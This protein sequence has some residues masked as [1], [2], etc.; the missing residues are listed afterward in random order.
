[1]NYLSVLR[2]AIRRLLRRPVL[3]IAAMVTLGLAIGA[4]TAVFSVVNGVLLKPLPYPQ[5]DDLVHLYRTQ[6]PV[7]GSPISRP[8][9][10]E[11]AGRTDL[12]VTVAGYTREGATL[13]GADKAERIYKA[14]TT[15][16]FFQVLGMQPAAG[17]WIGAADDAPNAQ[18]SA[19]LAYGLARQRFGSPA[20]ALGKSVRVDGVSYT[21][22]GVAPPGLDMPAGT[23]VWL[24]SRFWKSDS[25]WG[26]N[27]VM[28]IG[29]L[30]PGTTIDSASQRMNA[31]A[32][33]WAADRPENHRDLS[34]QVVSFRKSEVGDVQDT[35]WILMGAVLLVL[36]VACTNVAN[37]IIAR[38]LSRSRELATHAAIGASR[39]SL[40]GL[41][42]T[43]AVVLAA[44]GAVLGVLIASGS[45]RLLLSLAPQSLPRVSTVSIDGGVLAFTLLITLLAMLAAAIVPAWAAGNVAPA[46]ALNASGRQPGSAR[47]HWRSGLVCGEI[48]VSLVLLVGA[49]IL[50]GSL[51]RLSAVNPGFD[52]NNLLVAKVL[53]PAPAPEQSDDAAPYLGQARLNDEFLQ[54]VVSAATALPGVQRAAAVDAAPLT[55]SNWSGDVTIAGEDYAPGEEPTVDWRWATP[56]YFETAGIPLLKGRV[57]T[58]ADRA[59]TERVAVVSRSFAEKLLGD[60]D[61]LGR[62]FKTLGDLE[63]RIVGIVGDVRQN[64][65]FWK[66]GPT[67]YFRMGQAPAPSNSTLVLRTTVPPDSLARPL[68]DAV[69]GIDRDVPVYAVYS[70]RQIMLQSIARQRFA[71]LLMALFAAT[72]VAIAAVGLFGVMSYTVSLRT[73]D[74]GVRMAIGASRRRVLRAILGEGLRLAGLGSL[75]GNG[76]ALAASGL[77]ASLVFELSPREPWLYLLATGLLMA[78]AA[79]ASLIPAWR[80][81]RVNPV[82]ALRYE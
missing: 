50:I 53:L 18:P 36:L 71:T 31:V 67:V 58:D 43:E 21:V 45:T 38:V 76:L 33:Q 13:A 11:L 10:L 47:N 77:L 35:L 63:F 27:Y 80:A 61:W 65:L 20:G 66:P 17:R 5:P 74:I 75:I 46:A 4:G 25:G 48:A 15:P 42:A 2:H 79:F 69:A 72:T 6:P 70:M 29:R 26:S 34:F 24:P 40:A 59:D 12:G 56:G 19:V 55:T 14:E 52:G 57:F 28:L 23:D 51:S 60:G 54:R 73:H 41:A 62:K 30:E 22:V 64:R 81:A 9:F 68:S 82:E 49:I 1:M 44:G 7:T 37:L 3:S 16:R 8:G 78:V 39:R 32:Q